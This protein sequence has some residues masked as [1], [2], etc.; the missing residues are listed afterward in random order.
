MVNSCLCCTFEGDVGYFTL[1]KANEKRRTEWVELLKLN[2]YFIRNPKPQ[3]RVC[4][5]HFRY[6]DINYEGKYMTLKK[7]TVR[8]NHI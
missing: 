2:D 8:N 4:W 3:H 6:E 7:G 5:R 1:P